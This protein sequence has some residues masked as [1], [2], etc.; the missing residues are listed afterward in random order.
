[1][2]SKHPVKEMANA[3]EVSESGYAELMKKDEHPRRWKGRELEQKLTAIFQ[4]N[5]KAYGPHSYKSL[6]GN[7]ESGAT[8][9]ASR[10]CSIA[11]AFIRC[12]RSDSVREQGKAI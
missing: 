5:R 6:W 1:M 7:R 8:R 11:L 2:K 4:L 9:S 10:A 12:R 3:L